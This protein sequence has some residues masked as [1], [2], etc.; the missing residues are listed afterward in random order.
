MKTDESPPCPV[1]G[2]SNVT[3]IHGARLSPLEPAGQSEVLAYRCDNGHIFVRG[4][5]PPALRNDKDRLF[6]DVADLLRRTRV[7]IAR[8]DVLVKESKRLTTECKAGRT[9]DHALHGCPE[10]EH[11]EPSTHQSTT[12]KSKGKR[13]GSSWQSIAGFYPPKRC[14]AVFKHRNHP[15]TA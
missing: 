12:K 1:C 4:L 14:P 6:A 15:E 2:I 9:S 11:P 3:A 8:T 5:T 7:V 10:A 13:A